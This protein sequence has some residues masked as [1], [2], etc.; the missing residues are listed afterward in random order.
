L[1]GAAVADARSVTRT[2]F[3]ACDHAT[4]SV[5]VNRS[6]DTS[7]ATPPTLIVMV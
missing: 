3:D 2:Y 1:F 5:G 4:A 7:A 6:G